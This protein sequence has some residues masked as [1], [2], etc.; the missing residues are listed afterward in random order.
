MVGESPGDRTEVDRMG[1]VAVPTE[2]YYGA[3]TQRASGDFPHTMMSLLAHE[4][5]QSSELL[6]A[7]T[8]NFSETCM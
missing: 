8:R 1:L 6:G 5:L 3:S 7:A 4:L 2:A